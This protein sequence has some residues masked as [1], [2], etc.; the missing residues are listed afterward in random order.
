MTSDITRSLTHARV[1]HLPPSLSYTRVHARSH[2]HASR[3][4]ARGQ[5]WFGEGDRVCQIALQKGVQQPVH[6]VAR[7]L[8]AASTT[9]AD[10]RWPVPGDPRKHACL[11]GTIPRRRVTFG[12]VNT[13]P[14]ASLGELCLYVHRTQWRRWVRLRGHC[15]GMAAEHGSRAG[16]QSRPPELRVCACATQ[17]GSKLRMCRKV[18]IRG[19]QPIDGWWLVPSD[20]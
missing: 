1:F 12:A 6:Q 3:Y 4:T 5:C 17:A 2:S 8:C 16:R 14:L 15:V 20:G 13:P 19:M 11:G 9:N 10:E 18:G 7:V